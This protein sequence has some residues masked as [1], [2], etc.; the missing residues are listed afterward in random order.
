MVGGSFRIWI[1]VDSNSCGVFR[2]ILESPS[3][4]FIII[5]LLVM[6]AEKVN[7]LGSYTYRRAVRG[8]PRNHL[9]GFPLQVECIVGDL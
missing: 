6:Y 4:T 5:F 7:G 2:P 1:S 9:R 3:A 8:T